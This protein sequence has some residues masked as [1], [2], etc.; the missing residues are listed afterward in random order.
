[1][2]EEERQHPD[3][4]LVG[5]RELFGELGHMGLG[6]GDQAAGLRR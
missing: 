3:E 6:A 4:R 2:A 5:R 1:V